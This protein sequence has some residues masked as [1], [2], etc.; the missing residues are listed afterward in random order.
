MRLPRNSL[1]ASITRG[2][3]MSSSGSSPRPARTGLSASR[4]APAVSRVR[5]SGD[6]YTA[7]T[8]LSL[9]SAA[10]YAPV[11]CAM[12]M[13]RSDRWNPGSRSYNRWLG[14]YTLP[15]RTKCMVV[16]GICGLPA[17]LVMSVFHCPTFTGSPAMPRPRRRLPDEHR[18][19][20]PSPTRYRPG[21]TRLRL[22]TP[23]DTPIYHR[24]L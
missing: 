17:G 22:V 15:W 12:R 9:G 7:A 1:P 14:L 8:V 20:R 16:V 4:M 10:M 23:S 19:A 5:S 3:V 6:E 21:T 18:P 11:A 24:R 2:S 13:P